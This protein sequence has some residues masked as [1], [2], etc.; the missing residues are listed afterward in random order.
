[1]TYGTADPNYLGE[2]QGGSLSTSAHEG[3]AWWQQ[4]LGCGPGTISTA[5]P[6]TFEDAAPCLPG[7]AVRLVTVQ[8]MP[9]MWPTPPTASMARSSSSTSSRTRSSSELSI[10]PDRTL[11]ADQDLGEAPAR[12][13]EG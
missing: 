5:G 3:I 1:M 10:Y 7:A 12:E 6:L 9:H 13:G 8:G 4:V 11:G 2:L